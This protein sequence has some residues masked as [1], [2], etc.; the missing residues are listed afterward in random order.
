MKNNIIAVSFIVIIFSMFSLNILC[1]NAEELISSAVNEVKNSNYSTKKEQIRGLVKNLENKY[2]DNIVL[3]KELG[4]PTNLLDY[5]LFDRIE[6][7][8][9]LVGKDKWMFYKTTYDGKPLDDYEGINI[10]TDDQMSQITQNIKNAKDYYNS[11]GIDFQLMICPNKEQVYSEYMPIDIKV[12]NTEKKADKLIKYLKSNNIDVIDPKPELLQYKDSAQV[13][14]KN[15]THWN[16]LGAFIGAQHINEAL[17]GNRESFDPANIIE[18]GTA[19]KCDLLKI[20]G[21]SLLNK[22]KEYNY[23]SNVNNVNVEYTAVNENLDH[24]SSNA[25][26]DKKVLLIGDSFRWALQHWMPYYYS[27]VDFIHR[28][29][30]TR[31]LIDQL[32][33]DVIIYEVV[34]RHTDVL[35]NQLY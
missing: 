29:Y 35:F 19:K 25:A 32:K 14:Y 7:N 30:F 24:Y 15:D 8:A 34:E 12:T 23:I 1:N 21:L 31:D 27:S 5:T 6:S 11:L 28:D 9:S 4:V 10:Y 2:N 18:E 3:K 17:L 33:P 13:Y 20:L 22:D 16:N 26:S